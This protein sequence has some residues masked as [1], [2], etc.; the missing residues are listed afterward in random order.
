MASATANQS[1]DR[2]DRKTAK[3]TGVTAPKTSA[4][5]SNTGAG[6]SANAGTSASANATTGTSANAGA[7]TGTG[8]GLCLP[9]LGPHVSAA[10]LRSFC[11]SAEELGYS[12]L[13]VQDHF[14]YSLEP[15]RGYGSAPGNRSPLPYESVF[16]PTELLAAAAA[17]TS[18]P[19]LGTSVLV[20]G[21]HWPVPLAQRL[22][23]IDVLSGGRLIAGFGVGWNAE[24]HEAVGTKVQERGRRME[25]F[26]P[27]LLACWGPDPV[28]HQG[29]VF[30]V[31]PSI[32]RP[33]PQQ[34]PRP[35]IIS[36]MWSDKGLERTARLFD[37]W[38]P[39]MLPVDQVVEIVSGMDA[40]RSPQQ[41]PLE[42]YYRVFA[43]APHHDSSRPD[44][45]DKMAE[46]VSQASQAGF[47]E[48]I[49]EANFWDQVDSA[50]AWADLPKRCLPVLAAAG[51]DGQG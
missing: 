38:N 49:L 18:T 35:K 40:R 20:A 12:S 4:N 36:G 10:A 6:A 1:A 25:D 9:Q 26:I 13:W 7:T 39:A 29:D 8:V 45:L 43:Q 32:I 3:K 17:W 5:P 16:A 11:E 33:K 21:H 31:P 30:C 28:S 46:A 23:T 48:V 34:Q 19:K 22:A 50:Q 47:A 15:A 51:S 37:G 24:E 2:G 14:M 41:G 42:V 27:A 44:S